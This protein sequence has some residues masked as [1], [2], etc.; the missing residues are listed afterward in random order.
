MTIRPEILKTAEL[1]APGRTGDDA[2]EWIV[3]DYPRLVSDIRKIRRRLDQVDHETN[4][5]DQRLERLQEACRA[6]LEL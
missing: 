4:A 3:E 6:I 5:L 2:I 1:Y